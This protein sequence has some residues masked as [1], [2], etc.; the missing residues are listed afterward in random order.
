MFT[1]GGEAV[2]DYPGNGRRTACDLCPLRQINVFR[3]F[4]DEE[5]E[6]MRRFKT[7]EISVE[8]GALILQEGISSNHLYTVLSGWAF[9]FNT[10][11]DGRRQ[12]LNFA[13]AGDFLGLQS[14]LLTEMNHSVEALSTMQLCVFSREKLWELY[15]YHPTL[16]YDLT[17]L[18]AREEQF[19]DGHLLNVGR[20]TALERIAYLILHLFARARDV[21]LSSSNSFSPPLT[22]QHLADTLGMS[23]VHANKTLRRLHEMKLVYWRRKQ[24]R[25][26]DLT[27]LE[28]LAHW[29]PATPQMRPLI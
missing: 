8:S 6:F 12:I 18:A 22:Q 26:L 10:L 16:S 25:I 20:R 4:S 28:K 27:K 29:E 15:K 7:G 24:L 17:W 21:G 1:D 23:V 3:K 11:P 14:S 2:M 13:L 5:L 19:L 9:R